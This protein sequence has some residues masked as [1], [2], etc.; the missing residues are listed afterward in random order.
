MHTTSSPSL[1]Q[2]YQHWYRNQ[3][4][5]EKILD[6]YA[7]KVHPGAQWKAALENALMYTVLMQKSYNPDLMSELNPTAIRHGLEAVSLESQ[8]KEI[9]YVYE[10]IKNQI[11]DPEV[12]NL[13]NGTPARDAVKLSIGKYELKRN[14]YIDKAYDY[15]AQKSGADVALRSILT[16]SIRYASIYA[17]TR[18]IGPP[19]GVYDDFYNW[20]VRN[21]GF[22]SPFNARLLGKKNAQ[23]YSLFP[24]TDQVFGSGGSFFNL[25]EP[26]NPGHWSLDPPF[27]PE[28]MSKV[29]D[30]IEEW[31]KK[32]PD[33]AI[34]Y[35]IPQSHQ[36]KVAPEETVV[37]LANQH[38]YEGLDGA[39]HPLPVN[40]CVHRYGTLKGFSTEK[41][42]QG[43]QK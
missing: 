4:I 34:L 7:S 8:E 39:K 2:E 42:I 32:F 38:Y 13:P 23:F 12:Q 17:E 24:D 15:V 18:H 22:A 40:V 27:L 9:Q 35:I 33:T 43:Y 26:T 10:L 28:T 41:I 36:P 5:L 30:R 20:G 16:A 6:T 21:E 29:D 37:L 1:E 31:R 11:N 25:S 19:Q 14:S 3:L